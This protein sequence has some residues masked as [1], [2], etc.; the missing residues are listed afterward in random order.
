MGRL[1]GNIRISRKEEVA[2]L[3]SI[4]KKDKK[5]YFGFNKG[6]NFVSQQVSGEN[7]T[8]ITQRPEVHGFDVRIRNSNVTLNNYIARIGNLKLPKNGRYFISFDCWCS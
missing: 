3:P 7:T 2:P 6:C 5:N 8:T 4:T 1:S